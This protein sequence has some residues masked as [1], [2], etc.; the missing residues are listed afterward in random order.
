MASIVKEDLDPLLLIGIGI[1]IVLF[2]VL[3]GFYFLT[4]TK[5]RKCGKRNYQSRIN[6]KERNRK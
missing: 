6:K 5:M 2:F 3:L 4:K 1:V